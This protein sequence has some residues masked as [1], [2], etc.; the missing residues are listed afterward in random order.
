MKQLILHPNSTEQETLEW[1]YIEKNLSRKNLCEIFNVPMHVIKKKLKKY[2]VQKPAFEYHP[3]LKNKDWMY[4]QFVI[5]YRTIDSI[6]KELGHTHDVIMSWIKKHDINRK[7]KRNIDSRVND[8]KFLHNEI[9]NLKTNQNDLCEK[10]NVSISTLRRYLEKHGLT[11]K[12]LYNS[13]PYKKLY[14]IDWLTEKRKTMTC[15][16]I[17]DE[18]GLV[19]TTVSKVCRDFKILEKPPSGASSY[20]N[21]IC[22]YLTSQNINFER[23]N[24]SI[25]EGKEIDIFVPDHNLAIEIN[26]NYW[27][28]NSKLNN[29][30]YHQEKTLYCLNKNVRLFHIWE[31]DYLQ[32]KNIIIDKIDSFCK[33]NRKKIRASKCVIKTIDSQTYS[34]FLDNNH[35]QGSIRSSIKYALLHDGEIVAV[36][37]LGKSRYNKNYQ[38]EM[39][40]FC[41]KQGCQVYGAASK[42][43]NRFLSDYNNPETISYCDLDYGNGKMYDKLEFSKIRISKPNYFY[44][45]QNGNNFEILTRYQAQKHKLS[46]LLGDG[47]N[48]EISEKENMKR[49]GYHIIYNSGNIVF[50]YKWN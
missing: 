4:E 43:W 17:A 10:L 12:Q 49:N 15:F 13:G 38:Y 44:F 8:Y 22:D 11:R 5:N 40:R 7:V 36:M 9:V 35:I 16:Q 3:N 42:L 31:H 30:L 14:D 28:S 20:E 18:L 37:G 29:K 32:K 1:L 47:F 2:G 6:S 39:L 41:T 45:K 21:E 23:R 19:E 48:K 33:I 27:H 46:K 34:N 50:G 25:L 24:R 26:G